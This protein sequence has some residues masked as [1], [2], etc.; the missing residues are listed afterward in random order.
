MKKEPDTHGGQCQMR[1]L[2]QILDE[3]LSYRLCPS[4]QPSVGY[5]VLLE[6]EETRLVMAEALQK[7][8]NQCKSSRMTW[9]TYQLGTEELWIR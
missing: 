6:I 1:S 7:S 2:V 9:I 8:H 4:K 3:V 5:V